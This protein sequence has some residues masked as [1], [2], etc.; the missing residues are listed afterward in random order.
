LNYYFFIDESGDHG[1]SVINTDFPVFLLCGILIK[2]EDYQILRNEMDTLKRS[3]WDNKE[4][5]F[6]SRDIRKCEKEFQKLFDLELKK[7]FYIARRCV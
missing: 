6:H 5:I 4:V 2:E 1:L 3:I 7:H